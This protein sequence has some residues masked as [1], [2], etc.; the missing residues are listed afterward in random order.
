MSLLSKLSPHL[1][2]DI[3]KNAKG[4]RKSYGCHTYCKLTTFY[5]TGIIH[6]EG[7]GDDYVTNSIGDQQY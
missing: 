2:S 4:L 3:R 5:V 6:E 1:I 7:G